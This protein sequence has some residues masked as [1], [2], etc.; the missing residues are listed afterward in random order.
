MLTFGSELRQE[1]SDA[2]D[3]GFMLVSLQKGARADAQGRPEPVSPAQA[4]PITTA[5]P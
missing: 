1:I 4:I 3:V 5:V 2:I